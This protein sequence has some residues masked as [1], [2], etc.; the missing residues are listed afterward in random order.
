M[1]WIE[2]LQSLGFPILASCACGWYV[3]Y[4]TDKND[5]KT[6]KQAE[7]NKE[8][9]DFVAEKL[10]G[11]ITKAV[12]SKNLKSH[13]VCLSAEGAVSIEMEKYFAQMP[14]DEPK[15]TANKVLELNADHKTFCFMIC[16]CFISS[17]IYSK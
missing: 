10:N 7:E 3:K 2:V 13:P 14:G 11:K 8:L 1:D 12:I 15:P 6:E 9:L 4:I 5:E 17:Y 16:V